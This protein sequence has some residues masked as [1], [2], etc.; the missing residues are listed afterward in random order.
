MLEHGLWNSVII[1]DNSDGETVVTDGV[2]REEK[3]VL[4]PVPP[5]GQLVE[6]VNYD[7]EEFIPAGGGLNTGGRG[8]VTQGVN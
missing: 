8:G 1:D 6:I 3:K 7:G 2:G 5:P 4:I